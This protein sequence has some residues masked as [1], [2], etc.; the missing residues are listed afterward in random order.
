VST[1]YAVNI[2]Q[3]HKY[4]LSYSRRKIGSSDRKIYSFCLVL[5]WFE[6]SALLSACVLSV[7]VLL[8]RRP[9]RTIISETNSMEEK[10]L[11]NL[12]L[13]SIVKWSEIS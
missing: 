10:D 8:G 2:F 13:A 6:N 5:L 3:H 9:T 12:T 7:N 4:F 1:T 11:I